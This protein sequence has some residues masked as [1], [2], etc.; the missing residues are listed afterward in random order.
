MRRSKSGIP[1]LSDELDLGLLSLLAKDPKATEVFLEAMKEHNCNSCS[2][3]HLCQLLHNHFAPKSEFGGG[4]SKISIGTET[5]VLIDGET[6]MV[7]TRTVG[8]KVVPFDGDINME[9]SEAL[10][11]VFDYRKQISENVKKVKEIH[12][13]IVEFREQ[14]VELNQ[15][16]QEA[17]WVEFP[18]LSGKTSMLVIRNGDKE[19][20]FLIKSSSEQLKSPQTEK[21]ISGESARKLFEKSEALV[22]LKKNISVAE[23]E[24]ANAMNLVHGQ[25][26]SGES[27]RQQKAERLLH[28]H[29]P[30]VAERI[31]EIKFSDDGKITIFVLEEIDEESDQFPDGLREI[32]QGLQ[33]MSGG[34]G[35]GHELPPVVM[36][37]LG[38]TDEPAKQIV[39]IE[40]DTE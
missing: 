3:Q 9:V 27:L 26:S 19:G 33:K 39:D 25:L 6:G 4:F 38:L 7:K 10:K 11:G 21:A 35:S 24:L 17:I 18:S 2:F 34:D 16:L 32:L 8:R 28:K 37:A 22:Q 20:K 15:L 31:V 14:R 40:A 30:D 23:E 29:H 1:G 12:D 13:R 5:I 36:Q